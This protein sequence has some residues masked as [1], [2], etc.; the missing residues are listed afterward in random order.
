MAVSN[1]RV[2][3]SRP[4][5]NLVVEDDCKINFHQALACAPSLGCTASFPYSSIGYHE[6]DVWNCRTQTILDRPLR[7]NDIA[8]GHV[9][10]SIEGSFHINGSIEGV[11]N[12]IENDGVSRYPVCRTDLLGNVC[13]EHE[14]MRAEACINLKPDQRHK[15]QPDRRSPWYYICSAQHGSDTWDEAGN[16]KPFF[17]FFERVL[18]VDGDVFD[19]LQSSVNS[20][21]F[22]VAIPVNKGTEML[23][24]DECPV[25]PEGLPTSVHQPAG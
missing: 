24:N 8:G 20:V 19:T 22:C 1:D 2:L 3:V 10:L 9:G 23:P 17:L 18:R 6:P 11:V 16:V 13:A 12:T 4:S 21:S 25:Q 7:K 15:P 14:S 5:N